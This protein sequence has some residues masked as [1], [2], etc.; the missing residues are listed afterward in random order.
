LW[1]GSWRPSWA[2]A[3][4]A[5]AA[6]VLI[7]CGIW[8]GNW[9]ARSVPGDGKEPVPQAQGPENKTPANQPPGPSNNK[10]IEDPFK[11]KDPK[12]PPV[13]VKS[14]ALMAKLMEYDL[15]LAAP[16]SARERVETL[17]AMADALQEETKILARSAKPAEL[18]KLAQLYRQVIHDGVVV[19]A[20]DLPMDQRQEVLVV[21]T[22]QLARTEAEAKKLAKQVPAAKAAFD[23]IADA[24][25]AGDLQLH[26]LMEGTE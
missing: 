18:L 11:K 16:K 20:G 14:P 13:L 3:A 23:E 21:V 10:K 8:L 25:R 22:R 2:L 24:S 4:V 1:G 19:R 5:V 9:L 26:K 6:A 17:A 7:A 12:K 15:K